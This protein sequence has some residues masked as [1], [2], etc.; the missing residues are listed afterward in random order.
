MSTASVRLRTLCDP[1]GWNRWVI[2][3]LDLNRVNQHQRSTP[4][5]KKLFQSHI[6][7]LTKRKSGK[8]YTPNSPYHRILKTLYRLKKQTTCTVCKPIWTSTLLP[9]VTCSQSF[10]CFLHSLSAEQYPQVNLSTLTFTETTQSF[11]LP[12]LILHRSPTQ[13]QKNSTRWSTI[14]GETRKLG[15]T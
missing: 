2:V 6:T 7:L 11:L 8:S 14:I 10:S 5:Q 12:S 1:Q 4:D 9:F 3:K 15:E 13:Y